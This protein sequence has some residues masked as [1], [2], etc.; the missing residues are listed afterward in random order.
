MVG[1]GLEAIPD[2]ETGVAGL[3]GVRLFAITGAAALIV[4]ASN[5]R[6]AS[7]A[8]KMILLK[9]FDEGLVLFRIIFSWDLHAFPGKSIRTT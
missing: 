3:A 1:I 2:S 8:R 9:S 7:Q 5:I 6:P 4:T